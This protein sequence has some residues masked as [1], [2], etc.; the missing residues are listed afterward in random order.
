MPAPEFPPLHQPTNRNSGRTAQNMPQIPNDGLHHHRT[1]DPQAGTIPVP[2]G[3]ETGQD[4][5]SF[6][7][8][9]DA[10]NEKA[11]FNYLLKP[12]DS[13]TPEGVYWA[14]LPLWQRIKFVGRTE[15][16]EAKKELGELGAMVKKDPLSPI[17][18]Y[19]RQAV[20]PGAGL[21]LEGYVCSPITSYF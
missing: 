14:D 9:R 11:I 2:H 12:D 4:H 16:E 20:L 1:H 21:G 10:E 8:T 19:F 5:A 17:G 3:P 15:G 6:P 13:F 7:F 18:W